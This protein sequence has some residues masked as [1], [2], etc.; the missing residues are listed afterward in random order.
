MEETDTAETLFGVESVLSARLPCT[1]LNW[2]KENKAS[3]LLS[4]FCFLTTSGLV[5]SNELYSRHTD[6]ASTGETDE[7]FLLATAFDDLLSRILL[8]T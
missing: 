5:K 1:W 2:W 7:L 8:G 3:M 6:T 4:S